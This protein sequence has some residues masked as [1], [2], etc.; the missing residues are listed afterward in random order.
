[1]SARSRLSARDFDA[2]W[3]LVHELHGVLDPDA[4]VRFV[5]SHVPT[6][7]ASEITTFDEM[8]PALGASRHWVAP[9]SAVPLGLMPVWEHVMHGHPVLAYTLRTGDTTAHKIS[10][11]SPS[12]AFRESTFYNEWYRRIGIDH[13]LNASVTASLP[14]GI[15]IGLGLHRC[16]KDF[17]ERDRD[18]LNLLRPHLVQA[19]RNSLAVAALT[20]IVDGRHGGA[21]LLDRDGRVLLATSGACS[22]LAEHFDGSVGSDGSLPATVQ[23]W[24]D[25]E[26]RRFGS[27]NAFPAPS[28]PL[29]ADVGSR[30]LVVHLLESST[31]PVLHLS[32]AHPSVPS[33][34]VAAWG[35]TDREAEVLAW[36]VEGKT[37]AEIG[38]ILGAAS[39]TV[40]KHCER[41]YQKLGVENR[42][43]AVRQVVEYPSDA[44]WPMRPT[45]AT[46]PA[47]AH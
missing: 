15:V 5:L 36:V 8:R 31:G 9:E 22:A 41:I 34:A 10:D 26:L 19:Y 20:S 45:H 27:R 6:L 47:A 44:A 25:S 14:Q 39:R 17:T 2:L 33:E 1:V 29:V 13:A 3:R 37:N 11:F 35:L 32:E 21:I 43:A 4:F 38:V 12:P 23:A 16:R 18:V 7:I 46:R 42:T 30:R 24:V 28:R 40:D